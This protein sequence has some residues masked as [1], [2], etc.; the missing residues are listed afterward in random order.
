MRG[1]RESAL[2]LNGETSA[3]VLLTLLQQNREEV[4][5]WHSRVFSTSFWFDAT[6]LAVVSFTLAHP[7]SS[8]L[9]DLAALGCVCL[10]SF[11]FV[12]AMVAKG[13]IERTGRDL[14][15]LQSGLLLNEP[16]HYLTQEPVYEAGCKW[17]P[18]NYI[19]K[20]VAFNL[21]LSIGSILALLLEN[22][23]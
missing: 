16:G 1:K 3:T 15:L 9:R 8:A 11:H 23:K 5:F 12:I 14:L 22:A 20:L 2:V 13:A 21:L 19:W 18:P 10:A 6:V 17:L 4:R 7:G